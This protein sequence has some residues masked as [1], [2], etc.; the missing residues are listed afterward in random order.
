[1]SI[2]RSKI[3]LSLKKIRDIDT[4]L[5]YNLFTKSCFFS[6]FEIYSGVEV[7]RKCLASIIKVGICDVRNTKD[8]IIIFKII[9]KLYVEVTCYVIFG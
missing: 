2:D 5:K 7:A 1:M 3:P 8:G 9:L 4:N 6:F